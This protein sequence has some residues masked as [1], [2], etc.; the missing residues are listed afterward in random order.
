MTNKKGLAYIEVLIASAIL[1]AALIPSYGYF[2]GLAQSQ[3]LGENYLKARNI[4]ETKIEQERSKSADQLVVGQQ[5]ATVN[6]LPLGQITTNLTDIGLE[7]PGLYRLE[8]Q[9]NWR[10][11]GGEKTVQAATLINPDGY[12]L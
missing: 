1:T 6:Q 7:Q 9:L 12:I 8:V 11:P 3:L 4:M 2:T 10:E 5:V